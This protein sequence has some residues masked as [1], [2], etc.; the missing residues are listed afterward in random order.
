[1][2]GPIILKNKVI[3]FQPKNTYLNEKN[4]CIFTTTKEIPAEKVNK[5]HLNTQK[6]YTNIIY[7]N[8]Q[9]NLSLYFPELQHLDWKFPPR[10]RRSRFVGR[11]ETPDQHWSLHAPTAGDSGFQ[12]RPSDCQGPSGGF[13]CSG[14][15]I[16]ERSRGGAG[17]G[18]CCRER[19]K[20]AYIETLN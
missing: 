9:L 6:K 10:T 16:P 8:Q 4:F 14:A 12:T 18:Y 19:S 1:M 13:D 20:S 17:F 11:R 2:I 5:K 3:V 15:E 7:F